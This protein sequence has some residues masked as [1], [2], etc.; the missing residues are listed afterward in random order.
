MADSAKIKKLVRSH[1]DLQFYQRAYAL[2]LLLHKLCADLPKHELFVLSDQIRRAS[3]SICANIAEGYARGKTSSAEFKRFLQIALA[4]CA[5]MQVWLDYCS[6][7]G[8]VPD[9]QCQKM[10]D[11]YTE[12]ANMIFSFCQKIT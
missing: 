8:Y 9:S 5:E 12:I 11:E 1:K 10:Q 3:R 6:D 4:S 2:S 7:L